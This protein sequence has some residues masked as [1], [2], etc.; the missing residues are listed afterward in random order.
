MSPHNVIKVVLTIFPRLYFSCLS[1]IY[2]ITGGLYLFTIPFTYF[3]QP[4]PASPQAST[5]LFSVFKSLFI[6]IV[7]TLKDLLPGKIQVATI[8]QSPVFLL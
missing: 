6:L 3:V 7:V 4:P 5:S 2:S 1:L 8:D